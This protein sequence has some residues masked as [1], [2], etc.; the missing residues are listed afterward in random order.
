MALSP[1]TRA[2]I[3]KTLSQHKTVLFM[4]G[5]RNMPRCGFSAQVVSILDGYAVEY[6]SVDVLSDPGIREGIKEFGNWPTI[7]QLYYEGSLIGGSDII[8]QLDE[9]GEL[10]PTLGMKAVEIKAPQITL[11]PGAIS[12]IREAS[13]EAEPGQHLRFELKQGGRNIDMY[14]DNPQPSDLRVEQGGLTLL[15]DRSSARLGN[16]LAID[17][18]DGPQGG[19][20]IDNPNLPARVRQLGAAEL[21]AKLDQK[22]PLRLYDV[23]GAQERAIAQIAGSVPFDAQAAAELEGLPKDSTLVFVCHHGMR[24]Q[25]AA[26]QIISRGFRN[27]YNLRGGIDAWSS[28]VDPSVPRY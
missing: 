20:K 13:K 5:N 3:E 6:H 24:S 28:E 10:L 12:A 14:F 1:E 26:E 21:K 9:S 23:R 16:G 4:K 25:A 7:P 27:V 2:Q 18:V 8:K 11:S 19:F 22:M 15:F 17:F